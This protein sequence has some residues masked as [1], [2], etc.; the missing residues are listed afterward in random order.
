MILLSY[1][2]AKKVGE[3]RISSFFFL[4]KF[5]KAFL[6]CAC[7]LPFSVCFYFIPDQQKVFVTFRIKLESN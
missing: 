5:F 1:S 7:D 2:Y 6:F 3:R 4:E